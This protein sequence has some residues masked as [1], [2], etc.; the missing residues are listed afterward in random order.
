MKSINLLFLFG[1][2]RNCLRSER[3]R[4]LCLSIRRGI[5]QTV[6]II[7]SYHF[8]QMRTKFYPAS[9]RLGWLHKQRKLLGIINVYFEVTDQLL[10]FMLRSSN[11]WEKKWEY[12][13]AVHQ[14][15]I[16]FKKAYDSVRREVLYEPSLPRAVTPILSR[17][18]NISR[19]TREMRR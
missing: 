16:D 8:C 7:Q 14:L 10:L 13:E 4:S 12:D 5:K 17:L 9:C 18:L 15:F 1:K 2:R 19:N 3:I 6:V 11:T